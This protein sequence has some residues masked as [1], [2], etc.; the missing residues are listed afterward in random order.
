M[1][2]IFINSKSFVLQGTAVKR[3]I[4]RRVH[5][6]GTITDLVKDDLCSRMNCLSVVGTP[7]L[8]ISFLYNE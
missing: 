4:M 1:K 5:K 3:P 7:G 6:A 8:V 2:T